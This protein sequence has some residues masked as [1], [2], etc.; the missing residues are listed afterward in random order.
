MSE[1]NGTHQPVPIR[2]AAE[3]RRLLLDAM[4]A[5]CAGTMNVAQA[6]ALVGLSA[7]VHKSIRQEWDML[8]YA[9][10]HLRM[11]PGGRLEIQ[12]GPDGEAGKNAI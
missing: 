6:N 4:V 9:A 5:T 12:P 10:E 11:G 3:H 8:V 7:E 2:N 1:A